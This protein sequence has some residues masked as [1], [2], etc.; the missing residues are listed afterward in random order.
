MSTQFEKTAVEKLLTDYAE[1]LNSAN[2]ALIPSFYTADGLFMPDGYKGLPTEDLLGTSKGF[3]KNVRFQIDFTVPDTVID[4]EYAFV[5]TMAKTTTTKLE[6][7]QEV[8]QTSRDFFVLR[9]GKEG[10]KIYRYIF[11]NVRGK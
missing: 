1:A 8:K 7:N 2:T 9:K 4:G 6:K 3:F 10:W 5:Q 11:N